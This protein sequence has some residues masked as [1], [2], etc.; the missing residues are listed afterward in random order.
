MDGMSYLSWEIGQ[1]IPQKWK[2]RKGAIN[3]VHPVECK[4]LSAIMQIISA[5]ICAT[6]IAELTTI[7][8]HCTRC[9]QK[10]RS[11]YIG[12]VQKARVLNCPL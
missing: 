6:D 9:R 3:L 4:E 11:V 2:K 10:V 8:S 1:K 12:V 7:S 5:N